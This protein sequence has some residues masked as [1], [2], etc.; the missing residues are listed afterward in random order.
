MIERTLAPLDVARQRML[1]VGLAHPIVGRWLREARSRIAMRVLIAV[2]IA[3][4][5][6]AF[7]PALTLAIGPILFGV[8][9][10]ASSLRHLVLRQHLSRWTLVGLVVFSLAIVF[11]RVLEQATALPHVFARVE[12]GIGV[13]G[14]F[15]AAFL[16]L[17]HGENRTRRSAIVL[18]L[19]AGLSVLV[20]IFPRA[21][22]LAFVHVHNLGVIAL[23]LFVFRR[24]GEAWPLVLLGAALVLVVGGAASGVLPILGSSWGVDL[25]VTG[26]WLAPDAPANLAL[27]AVLAHAL[28]DSVHYA[29][30]LG[31]IPD[32][33]SRAE[34]SLTFRMTARSL[35]RDFGKIGVVV[36][37][38]ATVL[39]PLAALAI[40]A[41]V[42]RNAYFVFAGFHGYIEGLAIVY[43]LARSPRLDSSSAPCA[44]S[45]SRLSVSLP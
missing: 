27:A 17:R 32:E 26:R 25:A 35:R 2:T 41:D 13:T 5:L 31:V 12:V 11:V 7:A 38:L 30:W 23:W 1:R 8:P 9:H 24:R 34:G 21:G 18:A 20:L 43:V 19:L 6:A 14:A 22:K 15:C 28:T 37:V 45:P 33:T 10:V 29:F 40:R 3:F 39:V 36:V 42:V 16:A 44:P 4:V